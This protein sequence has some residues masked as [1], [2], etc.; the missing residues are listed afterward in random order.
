M[1]GCAEFQAAIDQANQDMGGQCNYLSIISAV[2]H[3]ESG[4]YVENNTIRG[5]HNHQHEIKWIENRLNYYKNKYYQDRRLGIFYD[6]STVS[7]AKYR[8]QLTCRSWS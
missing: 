1:G 6:T 2:Y 3:A 4:K 7:G 5:S 8:F